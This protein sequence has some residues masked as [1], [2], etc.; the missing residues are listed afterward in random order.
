MNEKEFPYADLLDR[1]Y[2]PLPGRKR[3]SLHDRAAQFA[4]FAALTGFDEEIAE[5]A[6]LTESFSGPDEEETALLDERMRF[7]S[8]HLSE[9][10]FISAICFQK[11]EK[12]TGGSFV[13]VEGN[14]KY[15]DEIERVITLTNGKKLK[16]DSILR[17]ECPLFL[18]SIAER[19]PPKD[20]P[21]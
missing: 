8:E 5:T 10:P 11:D 1:P 18:Q 9:R 4:P 6:R 15:L 20:E 3:M 12:K 17:L 16:L 7:L 19:L 2:R 21:N 13:T 14:L